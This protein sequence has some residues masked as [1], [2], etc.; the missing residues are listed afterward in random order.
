MN[1]LYL[2]DMTD[3]TIEKVIKNNKALVKQ[4]EEMH[5][6]DIDFYINDNMEN[7]TYDNVGT[8][9]K[10]NHYKLK[11]YEQR[12][13]AT[14]ENLHNYFEAY[15]NDFTTHN[16]EDFQSHLEMAL[17][18]KRL[19]IDSDTMALD[20]IGVVSNDKLHELMLYEIEELTIIL[21]RHFESLYELDEKQMI[22]MVYDNAPTVFGNYFIDLDANDFIVYKLIYNV[23][24]S[25]VSLEHE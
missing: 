7:L 16:K 23:I 1:K 9:E 15:I 21:E 25:V 4:L 13:M 11:F 14:I 22:E 10:N 17:Y 19:Y 2:E 24:E 8:Y 6:H 20:A 12:F 5:K 18:Y 3:I